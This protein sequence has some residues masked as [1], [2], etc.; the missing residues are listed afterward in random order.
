[1]ENPVTAFVN[2]TYYRAKEMLGDFPMLIIFWVIFIIL[3]MVFAY[4]GFEFYRKQ[5][6]G[7]LVILSV[8]FVYNFYFASRLISSQTNAPIFLACIYN[9]LFMAA[10]VLVHC[11]VC[12]T[13]TQTDLKEW[14]ELV[15]PEFNF[16]GKL[17]VG[18]FSLLAGYL[19]AH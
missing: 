19:T 16:A 5:Q 10:V 13:G 11:L 15:N 12:L 4:L 7:S 1:M 8:I 9:S 6:Y 3:Y 18:T 2:K 14:K 17:G